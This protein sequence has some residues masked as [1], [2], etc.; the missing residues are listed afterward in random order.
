[1]VHH[2]NHR[3]HFPKLETTELEHQI[4]VYQELLDRIPDRQK[5]QCGNWLNRARD[6]L[7]NIPLN[8]AQYDEAWGALYAI[9]HVY[10]RTLPAAELE[11]FVGAITSDLAYVPETHKKQQYEYDIDDVQ[12]RLHELAKR[13]GTNQDELRRLQLDLARL[14]DIGANARQTLWH[15]VNLL[16]FRLW[17]TALTLSVLIAAL[18]IAVLWQ[19]SWFGIEGSA[20]PSLDYP[21]RIIGIVWFGLMGGLLSALR[22]QEPLVGITSSIFY[23][24]RTSLVLRPIVGATAA[25]VLY[26]AQLSGL[27]V[28]GSVNSSAAYFVV[29]FCAGFSEQFFFKHLNAILQ[30]EKETKHPQTTNS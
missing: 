8:F 27:V 5:E 18:V 17:L 26:F 13:G 25:L 6:C 21:G 14:S 16:R 29:A 11:A 7:S 23:I 2:G 4:E 24:E 1:M 12:R 10:C 20:P 22:Q 30:R 15:R 3:G 9:R 28:I 19:P